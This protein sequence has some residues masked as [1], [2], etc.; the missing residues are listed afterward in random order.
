MLNIVKRQFRGTN[1][2]KDWV[3]EMEVLPEPGFKDIKWR[4][5]YD[6]WR[7]FVPEEHRREFIG[8]AQDPG[9]ERHDKIAANLHMHAVP[10][11]LRFVFEYR[12]LSEVI[13]IPSLF[14]EQWV[15]HTVFALRR[16]PGAYHP[17]LLARTINY[18]KFR[19]GSLGKPLINTSE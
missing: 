2:A 4:E 13:D 6:G 16:C 12:L 11:T 5:M 17:T 18:W 3:E 1:W 7:E 10:A 15:L 9:K 19:P 8:F 14:E